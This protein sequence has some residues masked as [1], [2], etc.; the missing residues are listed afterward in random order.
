MRWK[1]WGLLA[2]QIA[3]ICAIVFL[4]SGS[5]WALSPAV[6]LA[7]RVMSWLALAVVVAGLI[8]LGTAASPLPTPNASGSLRVDGLYRFVRH[9]IYSGLFVWAISVAALSGSI[10]VAVCAALLIGWVSVK[11]RWEEHRLREHYPDYADYAARTPRYIP[12]WPMQTK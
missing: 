3:L 6:A 7:L 9:P 8:N 2:V 12:F 1:S 11:A 5:T 4:P 10:P